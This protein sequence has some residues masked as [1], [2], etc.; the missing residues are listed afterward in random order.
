MPA[1]E[2]VSSFVLP[3]FFFHISMVYAIAK[4]NGVSVSKGD[5]DGIHQYP[6]GF[7]WEA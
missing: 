6:K 3:N 4:N 2:Y 5:F 1:S 7:S